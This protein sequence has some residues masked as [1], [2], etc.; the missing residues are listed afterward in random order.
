M[1]KYRNTIKKIEM[2]ALILVAVCSIFGGAVFGYITSEIKNYSG[3]HNLKK[4]QPSIPTRLYD[5]NGELIAELFQEKRNL[6]SFDELP[7]TVIN[8]FLAQED[9]DF[10][11]HFGINPMAIIRAM[12]K[13]IIAS[14]KNLRP[15]IVQGGSTI[16]QQLAKQ[17]FTESERTLARKVFEAVLALQ[18]EKK[19]T[20][21]EILEMYF[22]QVY[23]GHGCY[24]IKTAADFYFNK[25]VE[26]LSLIEGAVLSALPSKPAGYSP[27]KF[28]KEAYVKNRD[29]LDRMVSTG[30]V[31]KKRADE[32]YE[33]FW[34]GFIES[35]RTEFPTKTALS[36]SEDKAPYFT[37]YVRQILDARF[38]KD[39]MY[40]EGLSV[41]TTLN[42]KRQRIAEKYMTRG[43]EDQ[44]K[45]SSR[46]NR[47]GGAVD[48]GLF[49]AYGALRMIFSLPGLLVVND[50]TTRFKKNLADGF[51]DTLD[52]LALLSDAPK[53][54]DVIETF[55]AGISGISTSMKVEGAFIAVEPQTGYITSMIGGSEFEVSNQY[56][57]AVQARRQPGSAFKPFVYGSGIFNKVISTATVL[58]DVPIID[59]DAAGTTWSP[60]NYEG[61]FSGMVSIQKALAQSI[62]IISIRIFDLVGADN[63]I[64]YASKMLKV[65]QS[66]FTPSP[67]LALGTVELTPLEMATGFSIY[68]NRG[69]D[70][71]PF[72]IRYVL[73]RDGNELANIEEEVG[74]I[75]ASKEIDGTIQVIPEAVAYI[76][77]TLMRGVVNHGTPTY[78][79]RNQAGFTKQAAGKTGTTQNWTDAWFCG[80]TADIAAVI[81][82]GYDKPF[83]TLGKGQSAAG[84]AAPIWGYYMKEVYNG[85]PDPIFPPRPAGVENKGVC[86][87]TGLIPGPNCH[88]ISGGIGLKGSGAGR[89]CDGKH[90]EMKTVLE[91][92]MEKEGLTE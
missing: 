89:V 77:T 79:I 54:T 8:A 28:P 57:R 4:F 38:G 36:K 29:T 25:D 76:M 61:D 43:V 32:I 72:S 3:I 15:T 66:R 9:K 7:H 40:N 73:D 68:A 23:L 12:G 55:R 48:G 49:G 75:I 92:Y 91:R 17:L 24:G 20:K 35:L 62:N 80:F 5:V 88:K 60:D 45:I 82:M 51:I 69:R 13:N 64:D 21:N 50:Q 42:L 39:V 85:M 6:V 70:V 34:P 67:A 2:T 78:A 19:F 31:D 65:P 44:N 81:W 56:N 87:Y 63:V 84:L 18:I 14:V 47:M 52:I 86:M 58:P 22:N 74:N 33:A 30:F 11:E 46:M 16:T 10:Y 71:I 53:S 41:Y 90:Y 1:N 26:H 37:D 83:M 27:L 59:I